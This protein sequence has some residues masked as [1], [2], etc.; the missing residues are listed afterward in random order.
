MVESGSMSC[1]LR[2]SLR[3]IPRLENR[4]TCVTPAAKAESDGV[5]GSAGHFSKSARSGA[6]QVIS[7]DVKGQTRVE[8][9]R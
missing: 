1:P 4:E 3:G 2:G 8:L 7:V 9:S 5:G 6:P